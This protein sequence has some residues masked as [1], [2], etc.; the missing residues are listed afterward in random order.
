MSTAN[1]G[2]MQRSVPEQTVVYSVAPGIAGL[3]F[4][5][6]CTPAV[7]TDRRVA[8]CLF[9]SHAPTAKQARWQKE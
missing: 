2:A 5:V 8:L 3:L 7:A 6:N 1:R 9:C 4:P